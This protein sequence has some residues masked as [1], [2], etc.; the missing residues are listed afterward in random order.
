M[1]KEVRTA[2][3]RMKCMRTG[4]IGKKVATGGV[5]LFGEPGRVKGVK[6]CKSEKDTGLWSKRRMWKFKISEVELS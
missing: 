3:G 4:R 1:K 5:L 6:G 2:G